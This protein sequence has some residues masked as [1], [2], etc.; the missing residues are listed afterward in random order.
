MTY[1]EPVLP[2]NCPPEEILYFEMV[3]VYPRRGLRADGGSMQSD[4]IGD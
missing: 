1:V 2:W 3:A 4:P